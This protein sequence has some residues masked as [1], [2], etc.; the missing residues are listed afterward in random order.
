MLQ[1]LGVGNTVRFAAFPLALT[2]AK[3]VPRHSGPAP[4]APRN[5]F[6]KFAGYLLH[7]KFSETL[8]ASQFTCGGTRIEFDT[9]A[10]DRNL[11][12]C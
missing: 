8:E 6:L 10:D 7:L 12:D 9:G 2:I 3:P 11:R 1:L 5:D 4:A